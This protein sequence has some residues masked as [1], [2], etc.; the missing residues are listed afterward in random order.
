[1]PG[2]VLPTASDRTGGDPIERDDGAVLR[3]RMT[4]SLWLAERLPP[5]ISLMNQD[6]SVAESIPKVYRD[7]LDAIGEL[8]HR[9]LRVDAAR[10]RREAT[11]LYS[12]T[13]DEASR[14]RLELLVE[15]VRRA[16][17]A[18]ANPDRRDRGRH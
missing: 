9:G 3:S 12:T 11:A 16:H 1:M 6:G 14:R 15:R 4:T 8:E 10:F 17:Q 2:A 18:A 7:A 13:W 5:I